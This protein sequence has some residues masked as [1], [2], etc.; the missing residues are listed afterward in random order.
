MLFL[1]DMDWASFNRYTM[2]IVLATA[3]YGMSVNI[4]QHRL[5]ELK[6]LVIASTSFVFVGVAALVLFLMM[7]LPDFHDP[8]VQSATFYVVLLSLASTFFATIIFYRL[9]QISDALFASSVS[10]IVPVIALLWG[11]ID[12]EML[13][14]RHLI[15]LVLILSG[16]FMIRR[17]LF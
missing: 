16:V 7:P 9:V 6:P 17:R 5:K 1:R 8:Q 3:C 15:A 11:L 14:V 13:N 4:V 2:L 10:Y 12:G